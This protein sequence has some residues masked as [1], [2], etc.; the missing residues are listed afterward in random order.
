[1]ETLTASRLLEYTR[2]IKFQQVIR[3]LKRTPTSA[4]LTRADV[5]VTQTDI[6]IMGDALKGEFFYVPTYVYRE[7]IALAQE[8]GFLAAESSWLQTKAA[9]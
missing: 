6:E 1:V 3:Q 5:L 4:N 9:V 8:K 2:A 7:A